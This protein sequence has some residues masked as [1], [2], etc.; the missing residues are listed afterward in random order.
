MFVGGI[1]LPDS[2]SGRVLVG[3][4]WF[5]VIAVVA[6]YT[7][8]LIAFLAVSTVEMPFDTLQGLVSQSALEFGTSDGVALVMLFRVSELTHTLSLIQCGT[9]Y[10][11]NNH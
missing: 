1:W 3:C 8:N 2:Q 6:I 9:G 10:I 5:F 4:F 11:K 7:G